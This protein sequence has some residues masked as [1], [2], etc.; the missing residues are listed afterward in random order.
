MLIEWKGE[1][2]EI[3]LADANVNV[4]TTG[5]NRWQLDTMSCLSVEAEMGSA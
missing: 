1:R 5:L 4:A 2:V 3:V